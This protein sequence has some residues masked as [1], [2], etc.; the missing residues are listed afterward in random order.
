MKAASRKDN[1][2]DEILK[3]L[4]QTLNTDP[5]MNVRLVALEGLTKF[6]EEPI[7][8]K[9]LVESLA[10]QTDPTI[11]IALIQVLVQMKEKSA[12][13]PFEQIIENNESLPAVKDEAQMGI[14]VLT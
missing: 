5:N 11:Q 4:I 9:A 3:A 1:V 2:D 10:K 12:I 14:L 8:K 13:K 6:Y 7:V